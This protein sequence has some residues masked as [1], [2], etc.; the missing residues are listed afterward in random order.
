MSINS[1]RGGNRDAGKRKMAMGAI[2]DVYSENTFY[3]G[4]GIIWRLFD[5]GRLHIFNSQETKMLYL[6]MNLFME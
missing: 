1:L 3:N 2:C 4:R 6:L 5:I